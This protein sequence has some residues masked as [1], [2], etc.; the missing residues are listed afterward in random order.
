MV[1]FSLDPARAGQVF[2]GHIICQ[3]LGYKE[4]HS[5]SV[6]L[7]GSQ[8]REENAGYYIDTQSIIFFK[9]KAPNLAWGGI[10]GRLPGGGDTAGE[11]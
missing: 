5:T 9:G 8:P 1:I 6:P 3:A 2:T 10:Q 7:R 4:K 11:S